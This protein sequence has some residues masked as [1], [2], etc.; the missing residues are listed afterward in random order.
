LQYNILCISASYL[1]QGGTL[2]Y[3]TCTLRYDENEAIV[4]RFLNSHKEFK[5]KEV[6]A[7]FCEDGFNR[8]IPGV[9]ECDG[10]FFALIERG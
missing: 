4:K 1:K 10:F 8:L 3:S 6:E 5:L 9:M 2:M 7:P